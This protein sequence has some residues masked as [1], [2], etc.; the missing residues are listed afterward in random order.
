[1]VSQRN[2]EKLEFES[3][4]F[5]VVRTPLLPFDEFLSWSQ[6]I[7][8]GALCNQGAALADIEEAW[9]AD[10]KLVRSRLRSVLDRPEIMHALFL[11]SPSLANGISHWKQDPDSKKGL[12]AERAIVRYFERM[13]SRSTPFGIFAGYSVGWVEHES[14]AT[15]LRLQRRRAYQTC[16]RLDFDYLFAVTSALRSDPA[17]AKELRY[18]PNSS[19]HR[20]DDGWHYVDSRVAKGG[21]SYHLVRVASDEYLNAALERA[22][23][24]ATF[25][26]L[27]DAV[28]NQL[29]EIDVSAGDA[30]DYVQELVN[31]GIIISNLTPLLTGPPPLDDLIDQ[32]EAVPSGKSASTVLHYV[33]SELAKLDGREIG[34]SQASYQEISSALTGLPV[35]FEVE[36]SFQVDLI[37]PVE[38]AV[39]GKKVVDE[40]LRGVD[41]LC[42]VGEAG[43]PPE[44]RSFRE[45]FSNRYERALVPILEALDAEIGVGFGGSAN[46]CS[47]LL[48]GMTFGGPAHYTP[49]GLS[50]W[51][52][53]LLKKVVD[54]DRTGQHEL[55]LDPSEVPAAADGYQSRLPDA[56]HLC[57]TLVAPSAAAVD[58]AEF[59]LYLKGGVG[60]SGARMFG[61]FCH[62][63]PKLERL[64]RDHLRQEESHNPTAVYAEIAYLPEGRL[65]N[66]LCRPVL[67][68]YEIP[69]LARSGAPR[70]KQLSMTDLLVGVSGNRIIVYSERLKCEVIPRLTN[71]H[72]FMSPSLPP[73]YRFLCHLQNQHGVGVP[74]FNWG[75]LAALDFL[76]RVRIGRLVFTLATWHLTANEI[77]T[78]GNS[79]GSR[80]FL[81]MQELRRRRK[82]P[83]WVIFPEVD[84]NLT[85]DL[86]NPLSVDAL[87]HVLK[88]SRQ[89]LL[90]EMYPPP[91][92]LCVTSP[93]GR[94]HHELNV[95]FTRVPGAQASAR[96]AQQTVKDI[97]PS[98]A[99][100]LGHSVRTVPPGQDWLYLKL[101]GGSSTLDDILTTAVLPLT[102]EVC[103]PGAC[104]R[105]FFIRYADPETHLRIRF[106]GPPRWLH[107]HLMLL[108]SETFNPL[109]RSGRLRKI[110]FDTYDREIERYGGPQAMSIA[111]DIFFADSEAVLEITRHLQGDEAMDSRWRIAL[112]G[113]D[114]LLS[115]CGLS[116]KDKL[117]TIEGLRDSWFLEFKVTAETRKHLAAKFRAER[118][119]LEALLG[120]RAG[121]SA[122]LALAAPILDSRTHAVAAAIKNL[123]KLEKAG[124]LHAD[125]Q[126]LACTHVHMHINRVLRSSARLH[127][128]VLY[129]FLF[130]LYDAR[131]ARTAMRKRSEPPVADHLGN[132]SEIP[133]NHEL[134]GNAIAVAGTK[135]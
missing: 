69:Y 6:G 55:Q 48:K 112:L 43:E 82:L 94:F 133:G 106:N 8:S 130:N 57:A 131:L 73:V 16:S 61:R 25:Q 119:G 17:L 41:L 15:E 50:A 44:L 116:L 126:E 46:D 63:N 74:G 51:H 72:G 124:L 36:K 28:L 12:Q 54:C 78:L 33:R 29:G 31:S 90:V 129:D 38:C 118:N 88:R 37:K 58:A 81:A 7:R 56:F 89:A 68:S 45:A 67:R 103:T 108:V 102:R 27:V 18:W 84:N 1:M 77:E 79:T 122:E 62:A 114:R 110:Q 115:D 92:S 80:R 64:V 59:D 3:S 5:F 86:D 127:E 30:E 40:L 39:L 123:R 2:T 85:V 26:E 32:L 128:V 111:E 52:T 75:A 14:P 42:R 21:P 19:L 132:Y 120:Y 121:P 35:D 9:A 96:T 109:L 97:S 87:I 4:G 113:A 24:G 49:P 53:L 60:P 22:G 70:D 107:Q 66:V 117:T 93:E 71:A 104:S 134:R 13:S 76:P 23:N 91:E 95:P 65:G 20:V 101:Y 98:R 99:G 135:A 83:R 105:W 10:V 11:A 34:T 47:P 100:T 125:I